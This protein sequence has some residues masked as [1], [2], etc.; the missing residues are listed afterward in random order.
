[1]NDSDRCVSP[2]GRLAPWQVEL[3]RRTRNNRNVR[4]KLIGRSTNGGQK[5]LPACVVTF[6]QHHRRN[7]SLILPAS[8]DSAELR[9][10]R[11][12]KENGRLIIRDQQRFSDIGSLIGYLEF[13]ADDDYREP[14]CE[15]ITDITYLELLQMV[16]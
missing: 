2:C 7:V 8:I 15:V 12:E 16:D 14:R 3:I 13:V 5:L 9:Y 1:M 10:L 4:L 11:Y 6:D